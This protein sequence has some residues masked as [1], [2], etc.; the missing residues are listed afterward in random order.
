MPGAATGARLLLL[1]LLSAMA[2]SVLS[3]EAEARV[4]PRG[5][6]LC[7]GVLRG[8]LESVAASCLSISLAFLILQ[9]LRL[10]PRVPQGRKPRH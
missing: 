7:D 5:T 8:E 6:S 1:L 9:V 2:P 10:R 3:L 4:L